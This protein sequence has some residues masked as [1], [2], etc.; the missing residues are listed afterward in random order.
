MEGED[1]VKSESSQVPQPDAAALQL[2]PFHVLGRATARDDASVH[3]SQ[4]SDL[5]Q[6]L[7]DELFIRH[8]SW[9]DFF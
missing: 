8:L 3:S 2:V 5:F 6:H 9:V 1:L 4:V 7:L